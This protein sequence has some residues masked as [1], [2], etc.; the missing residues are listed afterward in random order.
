MQEKMI[1]LKEYPNKNM[2]LDIYETYFGGENRGEEVMSSHWQDFNSK[3]NVKIDKQ[4]QLTVFEGFGFG[5]CENI[6]FLKRFLNYLCIFSYLVFLPDKKELLHLISR[7]RDVL[8]RF[9][10]FLSY[11]LF[12]QICALATIRKNFPV[13]NDSKF[14]VLIIGDG[15]GFLGALIKTIYNNSRI[16]LIDI[17]KVLFFQSVNLQR[18]FPEAKHVLSKDSQDSFEDADFIY[19]TADNINL[20]DTLKFTLTV[21][22]ASMQEMDNAAIKSYFNII[23]SHSLRDNLFYCCNR[24]YKKLFDGEVTKFYDYPWDKD[25]M[26]IV[27]EGCPYYRYFFSRRP[28]FIRKFD[29]TLI[30]R[31]TR[32]SIPVKDTPV[33]KI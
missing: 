16:F 23:R 32:L 18:A 33:G 3:I 31:L 4:G 29:G 13:S 20:K 10:F 7:S 9:N 19:M 12:R 8:D 30:H 27:D 5:D 11:D 15:Y 26:H 21:N 1:N 28:P 6:S 2:I 24:E 17:G 22:I 25:D 14:N